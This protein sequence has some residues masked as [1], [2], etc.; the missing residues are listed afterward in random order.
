MEFNKTILKNDDIAYQGPHGIKV[1]VAV[2]KKSC[3]RNN[4]Q[5]NIDWNIDKLLHAQMQKI[6]DWLFNFATGDEYEHLISVPD[7]DYTTF[8]IPNNFL[9]ETEQN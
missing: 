5:E 1:S 8:K 4:S 9:R 7:E 3:L 2:C 6:L